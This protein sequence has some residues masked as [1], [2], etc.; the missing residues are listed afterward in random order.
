MPSLCLTRAALPLPRASSGKRRLNISFRA[1][2][3][4]GLVAIKLP[5]PEASR[6]PSAIPSA[7]FQQYHAA[8]NY[9]VSW[10]RQALSLELCLSHY[11]ASAHFALFT[12]LLF[13]EIT[14]KRASAALPLQFLAL[15]ADISSDWL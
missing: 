14:L 13:K 5:V 7:L 10:S 2:F 15:S 4:S 3:P 12:F 6:Q 9:T 11:C 1:P 8:A